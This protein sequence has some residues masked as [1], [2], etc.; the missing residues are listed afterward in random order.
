MSGQCRAEV[1]AVL[2]LEAELQDSTT[3]GDGEQLREILS[4]EFIEIGASGTRWDRESIL[5][6]LAGEA[7]GEIAIHNLTGRHLST[8]LIQTFWDS[9]IEGR[10]ARRSSL[11]HREDG[12]WRIIFHQGTPLA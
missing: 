5:D 11:W 3:R 2:H 7:T 1:E 4:P 10:W 6:L 8:D 9:Q 12:Q